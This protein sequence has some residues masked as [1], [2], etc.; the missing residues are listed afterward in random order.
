MAP[1]S[2]SK[3]SKNNPEIK[4]QPIY[5]FISPTFSLDRRLP[6]GGR[7]PEGGSYALPT[8]AL[9]FQFST[10]SGYSL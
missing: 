4:N 7:D 10:R 6:R 8:P 5:Y 1:D 9:R 2:K 3:G